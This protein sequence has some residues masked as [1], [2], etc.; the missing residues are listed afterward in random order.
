MV[1]HEMV[2][3]DAGQ[4]VKCFA[5]RDRTDRTATPSVTQESSVPVELKPSAGPHRL[6][7]R[8]KMRR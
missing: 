6:F 1:P 3:E 2:D 4:T 8:K 5:E 7:S